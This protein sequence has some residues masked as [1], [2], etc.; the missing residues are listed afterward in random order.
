MYSRCFYVGFY[1]QA[2]IPNE[3]KFV[4]RTPFLSAD[5][6]CFTIAVLRFSTP[7]SNYVSFQDVS[8]KFAEVLL[9]FTSGNIDC[10]MCIN[11]M[12]NFSPSWNC[13][14]WFPTRFQITWIWRIQ[15]FSLRWM[16]KIVETKINFVFGSGARSRKRTERQ[17]ANFW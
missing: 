11:T 14:V 6:K 17:F 16:Q 2:C 12:P 4:N 10:P 1:G 5:I 15:Q 3:R 9:T 7:T 8:I 13:V